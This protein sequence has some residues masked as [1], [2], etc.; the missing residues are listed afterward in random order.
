MGETLKDG[1]DIG[2]RSYPQVAALWPLI[3]SYFEAAIEH[4]NG[5][6]DLEYIHDRLLQGDSHL[7]LVMNMKTTLIQAAAA[8]DFVTYPKKRVLR[9]TA[10][11]GKDFH[12]W[13]EEFVSFL[14]DFAR[15]WGLDYLEG[16]MR[17]GWEKWLPDL[18][19]KKT[20]VL[21]IKEI[22]NGRFIRR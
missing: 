19:W 11:G 14:T 5:E 9:V 22:D 2:W 8:I 7:I 3:A 15:E 13:G 1:W 4:S 18:G 12:S 6:I 20:H 16:A 17:P 10:L 21:M